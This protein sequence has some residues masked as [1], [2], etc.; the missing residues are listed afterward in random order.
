MGW[1]VSAAYGKAQIAAEV[2]RI[3]A[4]SVRRGLHE[5]AASRAADLIVIGASSG[6]KVAGA[7][8]RRRS[9][10]ARGSGVPGGPRLHR[11]ADP[12]PADHRGLVSRPG[13]EENIAALTLTERGQA[14]LERLRAAHRDDLAELLEGW[15]PF[16]H[17]EAAARLQILAWELI[18]QDAEELH[19]LAGHGSA[20]HLAAS[21]ARSR[22]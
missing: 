14:A 20:D 16:R 22:A 21:D 8:R 5:F 15:S 10:G 7:A 13:G 18:D 2:A 19:Q 4:P 1:S 9:R 17:L 12:L 11:W 3:Q 6:N